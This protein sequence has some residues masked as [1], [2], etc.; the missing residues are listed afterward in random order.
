MA[1]RRRSTALIALCLAGLWLVAA[2]ACAPGRPEPVTLRVLASSELADMAPLL[3]AL[4]RDTGITLQIDHRGTVDASNELAAEKDRHR[5]DLAWLSSDR[6]Y[7]LKSRAVGGHAEKPLATNI[8]RS[9]VVIGMKRATADRLRRS[10]ADG[11]ISWADVADAAADGTLRFGMADPRHTNSGLAALVGV[12]TAAAGTGTALRPGDVSCERLHGFF[13]GHALT[14]EASGKLADAYA[15]RQDDL[16]ALITYESELL[17]LNGSGKLREPLEIVYP[18][19]GMVLSE[20]P[21]LLLDPAKRAAYDTLVDWLRS[22]RV[23]KKIMERTFRRPIDPELPRIDR[24]RDPVGNALYFPDDQKVLDRLLAD[25]GD[26]G[27]E[28]ATQVI[29]LLDFS[30]SMRGERIARLRETFDGLAG[31]DDSRSGKFV[32]FYR[33]ESLTVMRFG[34]RVLDERSVTYEGQRDLDRLR[35]FIASDDF[36]GST[37]IWS[38]L[39]SA[40]RT[41]ARILRE[42]PGRPATIVLMTDGENNAGMDLEAFLDAHARLPEEARK[43]S[44]YTISYGEADTR[45]LDR[46]ARGTGGRMVDATSGS[47]LS[48]FKEIRGCVQ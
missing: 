30:T 25:Y 28:R 40:Y 7:L 27:R 33:G 31:G 39:D 12:A 47:L 5:Y 23:Q 17:A 46:G 11:R 22:E 8:M 10:A 20:Y 43:V 16:N 26:P 21:L 29:F 44:T 1:A 32:R 42:R 14:D 19:D 4:R 24:L 45:E 6:Y 13:A 15:A 2:T 18:S 3:D 48:A 34:G 38:S 41:V 37:A 9:P 36:D 35:G